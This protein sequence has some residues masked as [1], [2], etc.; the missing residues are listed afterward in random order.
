MTA[1]SYKATVADVVQMLESED[2]DALTARAYAEKV[3][4]WGKKVALRGLVEFSN[5][6]AKNCLYCGI[7]RDNGKVKR[8]RVGEDEILAAVDFAAAERYGSI[9]LQSGE[10]KSEENTRFVERVLKRIH[11]K[12]GDNLGITI[13]L[14]EQDESTYRRWFQAGAH[15]YLLR[16]ETSNP[17]LY[18]K[19]HP[20]DH[21]WRERFECL[22]TLK[23]IG[24]ITGTGV[25]I[26]LPGQT[27][28][29]LARDVLFFR[30][31]DV[32]MVGMGPYLAN[33]D[34]PLAGFP[35]QL[36]KEKLLD[37][38]LRMIAAVRL[39]CRNVN[40]AATTALQAIDP[41][42]REKGILAGANV[43][44]PNITPVKY[45]SDYLL[46]PNKPCTGE[47]SAL[48]RG[49]LERRI[50]SIGEEIAWGERADPLHKRNG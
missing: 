28:E 10:L 43:V 17:E 14:G 22:R 2:L 47:D 5:I 44:M 39:V 49:C 15:R 38:S 29:D 23:K 42:G 35:G 26:G 4:F 6:C 37:L 8:Y 18:S 25:M 19:I 21:S 50:K 48:C 24:F 12:H 36:P 27:V 11:E 16:I 31:E 45:R 34:T 1:G 13:S 32:D 46:Y 7:R 3:S 30:D 41:E 40:I 20:A 9:V 33:G